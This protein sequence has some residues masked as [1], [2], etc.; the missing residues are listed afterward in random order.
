MHDELAKHESNRDY[1]DRK[2]GECEEEMRRLGEQ[3][4]LLKRSL[5]STED[6]CAR[7]DTEKGSI[8]D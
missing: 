4:S 5:N 2:K 3:M 6:E 8:E 7:M 1:I